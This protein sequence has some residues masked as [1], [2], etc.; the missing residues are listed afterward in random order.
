MPNKT[1]AIMQPTY[2]PWVGYFDLI[3]RADTFVF[4]DS[5]PFNKRSWQQRNRIR[6]SG[7]NSAQWLTVPVLTKD[8][9]HQPISEVEIAASPAFPSAHLETLRHAYARAPFFDDY[10]EELGLI[11]HRHTRLGDLNIDLITWLCGRMGIKA[12]FFRSLDLDASGAKADLL[13]EI[14]RAVGG[15][16]YLSPE[17]S[18]SYIGAGDAFSKSG[19]SLVYQDYSPATY[20]QGG[21]V[22]QPYLTAIDLL[23][24]EGPNSLAVVRSG[25]G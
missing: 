4:L 2:L 14:C 19:I 15:D 1:V 8:R 20:R 18:R 16:R 11:L 23:F 24:N 5:V 22:F 13:V 6:G 25:Q 9:R 17:G 21:S 12:E 10:F 3:D 7:S